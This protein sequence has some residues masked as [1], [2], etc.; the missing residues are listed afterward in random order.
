MQCKL[1]GYYR[2]STKKQGESGLGL[3]G[4]VAAVDAFVVSSGCRLVATYTEVESGRRSD[5]TE[6]GK[7]LARAKREKATLVIAKMD[8]LS[9]NV[10]F[11]ANLMEAGVDFIACDNPQANRLTVHILAAVAEQEAHAISERTKAALAAAKARG[12]VLGAARPGHP[13]LTPEARE[14]GR[15]FASAA[16]SARAIEAYSDLVPVIAELR[17]S[18]LSFGAIAKRL[19]ADGHTTRRGLPWNPV[20]VRRVLVLPGHQR[21]NQA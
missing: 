6:L 14:K 20:Q 8:R 7:A 10:A 2:V 4:Q 5:R 13:Q 15:T 12:T 9:R 19:N 21:A 1:V 11:I 17:D 16:I 3:E 18:G